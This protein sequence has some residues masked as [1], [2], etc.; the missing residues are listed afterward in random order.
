MNY[1]THDKELLAI[2]ENQKGWRHWTME[3]HDPVKIMTY[4]NNLHYFM[5][6]KELNHCQVRWVQFLS[7][8]NFEL[9]HRAGKENVI[10]DILSRC[11]QDELDM[12]DK[13]A[14]NLCL[15]PLEYF[16]KEVEALP[17]QRINKFEFI[18]VVLSN[19]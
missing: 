14:Q 12:G 10:A 8:Y 9:V 2:I 4:H 19:N 15:L 13:A 6:S 16:M 5:T 17:P 11:A 18:K 7:D 1:D 3:T